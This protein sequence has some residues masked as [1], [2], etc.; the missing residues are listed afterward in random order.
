MLKK[1][2]RDLEDIVIRD[3]KHG[4]P[5]SKGLMASSLMA[6]GISPTDAYKVARDIEGYLRKRDTVS[7]RVKELQDLAAKTLKREMGER[8]AERYVKW[9]SLGKLDKPLIIMI[10]GT[11]GVG[12]SSI[13]TEIAHRLG[14]T[15]IVSTD[16]LR[17]VMRAIFTKELMPSLYGSSFNAWRGLNTP[18]PREADSLIVGFQEQT[19]AVS[20]AV[21][22]VIERGIREGLS[23]VVEGVHMV[24]GFINLSKIRAFVVSLV[25]TVENEDLHRSHFYIRKLETGGLRRLEKY[26][27]NFE[28]I[29]RL[30]TYIESLALE[31]KT[32]II[33]SDNWDYTVS[34]VFEEILRKV[35]APN[36]EAKMQNV[37]VKSKDTA[38]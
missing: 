4:L 8:F 26:R 16:A 6:T 35:I 37:S 14:I 25:I 27:A 21:R 28:N 29:R 11:T 34:A 13:A 32:P 5:Y 10:G 22:A 31:K 33:S 24:P 2:R 20:V 17:E 1:D 12:K 7:I 38:L 9:Q 23:L 18:L 30:G 15:R 3:E 36:Q 19:K